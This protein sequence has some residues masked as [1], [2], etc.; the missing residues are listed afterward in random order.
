[1]PP[2]VKRR[3]AELIGL[4]LSQVEAA[5]ALGISPRSVATIMSTPQYRRIAED[6]SRQRGS[7][8]D[9]AASVVRD[10]LGATKP[11]GSPDHARRKEGATLYAQHPELLDGPDAPDDDDALLPGVVEK[12]RIQ[13]F[14]SRR[15]GK[16][17]PNSPDDKPST[18]S[19]GDV[20]RIV[21]LLHEDEPDLQGLQA[22]QI[23]DIL[24]AR[25]TPADDE[26]V[27]FSEDDLYNTP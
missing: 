13:V 24:R 9:Q 16:P 19:P 17:T 25:K 15:L 14:P 27:T 5:G 18:F 10:L 26:P 7:M 3:C 20:R 22:K 2:E 21:K 6:I 12:V 8:Q 11:D 4:G 23:E 1:L